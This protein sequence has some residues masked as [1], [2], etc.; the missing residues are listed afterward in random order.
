MVERILSIIVLFTLLTVSSIAIPGVFAQSTSTDNDEVNRPGGILSATGLPHH[1]ITPTPSN[2]LDLK[3]HPPAHIRKFIGPSAVSLSGGYAP[4]IIWTAYGLSS[5]T[6][7]HT[8][9]TDWN[10]PNLCGH[11][12][13]I[14]I[15]DAYDDPYVASDLQTFDSQFGLP[16]CTV[17]DGCFVKSAPIGIKNNSGWALEISLDVEWAHSVA[18]GAKI[19][20]VETSSNSLGS[21]LGGETTAVGSGAQQVSNSWGSSEFSSETSYDSYFTSP[22][23]SFFVASGDGGS[24]VE[25]PAA[26][27]YVIAVG[28]TTL[29][30][31]SSGQWSSETAWSGSS[32]GLSAYE[33]KPSYQ[34]NFV[35]GSQRAV[36]DVSYDG[37]PN[38]GVYV[39]DSDPING[40]SGWWV[41]GGTSAGAPQW[42]GVSA[43]VNSQGAKLVSASFGTSSAFYDAAV[44]AESNPQTS[45]YVATY[46]DITSGTN[47]NCG[48]L[49]TAGLG[50]DEVTGLG[51]PQVNNLIPYLVPSPTPDFTISAS[52]SSMTEGAGSTN[53]TTITITSVYGFAGSVS[54]SVSP[55]SGSSFG[56]SSLQITS[57][58]SNSTT[59]TLTPSSSTTYAITGS[60]G[61]LSHS[62]RVFVT[63]ESAPSSPQNLVVTAGNQQVSLSWQAPS[64]TGG[65]PITYTVF[66]N[67]TQIA[68]GLTT[69]SYADTGLTNGDTD[70]YY[71]EAVNSVGTSGP[72]NTVSV[73][74][75]ATPSLSVS[76]TTNQP[77]YTRGSTATITVHVSDQL[78]NPVSSASVTV[79]IK[80]PSGSTNTH[81]GTTNGSGNLSYNYSIGKH[82]QTGT[83]T[84]TATATKSGYISGSAT[85]TFVV[86]GAAAKNR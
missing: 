67:D 16:A 39:Y 55:S 70:T 54:L 79:S 64:S 43:I 35:S 52:Q 26:S 66:R 15:V 9:T 50:Y 75:Q 61:S 24:G 28:G 1:P 3:A 80:N 71:V 17:A 72:S 78:G 53:S 21:L 27:P 83:Y 30:V 81:T 31:G 23:A 36:P 42:A 47:G 7:T 33:P 37:D 14:A 59:L 51:S 68:S 62:T 84:V 56:S 60:S 20:L 18:P 22:T 8:T 4:T 48:T 40:Q 85:T 77:S 25:W 63:V 73:T 65:L 76:V 2:P 6:C 11:G 44:G 38:T 34:N 32:G 46:H 13:T 57:G 58:G 45:P 41:V 5:L 12:Q 74:P 86:S 10:D 29:N 69:T 19:V 49:C 82:A